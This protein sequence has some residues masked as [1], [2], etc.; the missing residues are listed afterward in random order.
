MIGVDWLYQLID[1]Y[2][3]YIQ[4]NHIWMPIMLHALYLIKSN[5][6]ITYNILFEEEESLE[7]KDLFW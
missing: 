5:D 4:F 3:H 2:L 6:Y 7:Q 1:N